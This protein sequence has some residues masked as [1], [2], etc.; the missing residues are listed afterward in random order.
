MHF[1]ASYVGVVM[2]GGSFCSPGKIIEGLSS[3]SA[4]GK[5]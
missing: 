1:R 2:V 5:F 3:R 4:R